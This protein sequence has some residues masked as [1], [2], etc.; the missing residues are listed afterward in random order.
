MYLM[1][2]SLLGFINSVYHYSMAFMVDSRF[3]VLPLMITALI[4]AL[5]LRTLLANLPDDS[6]CPWAGRLYGTNKPQS[7]NVSTT[8]SKIIYDKTS[9]GRT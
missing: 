6:V 9:T 5:L 4:V 2:S 3:M 7:V 8:C 1:S